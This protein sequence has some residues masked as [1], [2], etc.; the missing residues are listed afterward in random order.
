LRVQEHVARNCRWRLLSI[1]HHHSFTARQPHQHESPATNVPSLRVRDR[2]GKPHRDSGI[3]RVATRAED[4]QPRFRR[5]GLTRHY[6]SMP[7]RDRI[8][9]EAAQR[10]K[11]EAN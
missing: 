5:Q 4:L 7:G 2:Q 6:H 1:V 10:K 8:E 9:S 3:H 11:Q